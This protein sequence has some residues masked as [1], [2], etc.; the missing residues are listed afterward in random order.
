MAQA[1]KPDFVFLQNGRVHLNRQGRQF[2]RLLAAEVCASA[3]VM[4]V[5]SSWNV[6]AHGDAREGKWR[7]NKRMEW[8]T[9]KRH[10]TA[11][12]RLARAVQ[13]LRADA[14]SS[15]A[16]SRLKWRP[17][18]FKRTRPFRRKTKS[19][20]CA[21]AITFQTQSNTRYTTLRGSVKIVGYPLH[22]PVSLSLLQCVTVCYYISTVLYDRTY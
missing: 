3:V 10:M 15:P 13:T 14:H 20:F 1:L 2:S 21:C 11:N 7:G 19:G 17:C 8:V 18:R 16:S 12:H 22:S 4:V 6:M 5:E 9:S